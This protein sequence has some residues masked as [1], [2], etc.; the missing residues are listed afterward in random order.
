[1][2]GAELGALA[3]A[4]GGGVPAALVSA[5]ANAMRGHFEEAEATLAAVEAEVAGHPD[6]VA[7]LEQRLRVLHWGLGRAAQTHALLDRAGAWSSGLVWERRLLAL[8]T[9]LAMAED[10]GAAIEATEAA[11]EDPELDAQTRRLLETRLAIALFYSGRWNRGRALALR[12]FPPIPLRDYTGLITLPVY[13]FTAVESGADWPGLA[14]DF[15]RILGEGVRC[16]DHE[17]AAQ[18]AVGLGYLEFLRGRFHGASRWLAEAELHFEREDAFGLISDVHML[19]VGIAH[20][21]GD[22]DAAD[23]ALERMRAI[24][25][26]SVPRALSRKAYLARAEGWAACARNPAGGAS[27]LLVSAETFAGEMPG[28]TALLAY[29][30]LL[31]GASPSR[32]AALLAAAAPRCDAR[33]VAAY[34]AHADALARRDGQALLAVADEFATIGARRYAMHAAAHAG[35]AFVEAGRRDSARR[36]AAR[37]RELHEPDQGT[38]PPEIDGV[39]ADRGRADGAREPARRAS[40]GRDSATR[41]SPTGSSCPSAPSRPTCIARCR[42]WGSATGATSDLAQRV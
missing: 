26:G 30:A 15:A 13:R 29:D 31:A 40:P 14:A 25:G 21:T 37:A 6:A 11:L 5:R 41:R 22:A 1:M 9:T 2:L 4:D 24:D 12:H 8:R 35:G 20:A 28:F 39:D 32:A 34:A 17:A 23:R 18:A 7:Y 36:A 42:S 38:E 16:H 27:E 3:V 10:L 33:L 19:R